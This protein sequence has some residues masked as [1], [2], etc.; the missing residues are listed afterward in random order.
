MLR[1]SLAV[2]AL[3]AALPA[4][5]QERGGVHLRDPPA[6]LDQIDA[7]R[8]CPMSATSVTVGV[9]KATGTGSSAQQQLGTFGGGNRP[10]A[11]RWSAPRSSPAST[12]RSVAAHPPASRSPRKA[13]AAPWQQR[14]TRVAT[15]SAS[16][17]C[18]PPTSVSSTRPADKEASMSRCRAP[19][20]SLL[21]RS[22]G[23]AC[24][25]RPRRCAA[26]R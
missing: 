2:L 1:T 9:N 8:G 19:R 15:T 24:R 18:P 16:A 10:A 7:N 3:L 12:W 17:P 20:L 4:A 25:H 14:P 21:Y 11:I 23:A 6:E 13:R 26:S 22:C 5:A